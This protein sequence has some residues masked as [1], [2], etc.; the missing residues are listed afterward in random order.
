MVEDTEQIEHTRVAKL[1]RGGQI[2]E[3]PLD[4]LRKPHA[5]THAPGFK[6]VSQ[7][8]DEQLGENG[9]KVTE[10]N[11]YYSRRPEQQQDNQSNAGGL[12]QTSGHR[13]TGNGSGGSSFQSGG[14]SSGRRY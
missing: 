10:R 2:R 5:V 13:P 8:T 12:L 7:N 9:S 3:V 1:E 14:A 4:K 6:L 11:R